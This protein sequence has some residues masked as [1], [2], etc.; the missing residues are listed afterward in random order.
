MGLS[1][2][3]NTYAYVGSNPIGA[4]D[5]LGLFT[6]DVH[7][8]ITLE[9]MQNDSSVLACLSEALY[10]VVELD[11]APGSQ[12]TPYAYL[13]S[14]A[15]PGQDSAAAAKQS[16]DYINAQINKCDCKSLGYALHTAQ[17]SAAWGHQYQTYNGWV[18]LFHIFT[19]WWPSSDR[20]TEA[21][22]KSKNVIAQFKARCRNCSK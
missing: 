20:Q 8:T 22:M 9:A 16:N 10:G 2:G 3:V 11:F 7:A 12:T 15:Q 14:M 18:G 1:A 21:L 5:P 4:T 17:D 6:S 19:D 13:H